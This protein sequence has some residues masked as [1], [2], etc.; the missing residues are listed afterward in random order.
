MASALTTTMPM[1]AGTTTGPGS[2]RS[3]ARSTQSRLAASS[4]MPSTNSDKGPSR[5]QKPVSGVGDA[6]ASRIANSSP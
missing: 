6:S 4:T 3:G 5:A 2:R 1:A